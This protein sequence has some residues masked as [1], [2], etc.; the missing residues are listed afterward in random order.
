MEERRVI[1]PTRLDPRYINLQTTLPYGLMVTEVELAVAETYRLFH[2]LNDYLVRN[3]FRVLEDLLLGNSFN[4][5]VVAED[6]PLVLYGKKRPQNRLRLEAK[7][8]VGKSLAEPFGS[9]Q[10]RTL[11]QC[12]GIQ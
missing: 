4:Q 5:K 12:Y 1:Q 2:G 8:R 3:G 10:S 11:H 9:I 6:C 7:R